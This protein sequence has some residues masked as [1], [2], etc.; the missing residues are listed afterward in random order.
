MAT[1]RD[2]PTEI[3]EMVCSQ[4]DTASLKQLRLSDKPFA[5]LAAEGLFEDIFVML[6]PDSV[7]KLWMIFSYS[8]SYFI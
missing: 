8:K 2:L 1:M 4:A 5:Q 6:L 7:E 3:L